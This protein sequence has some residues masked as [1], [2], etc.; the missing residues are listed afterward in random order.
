MNRVAGRSD[1]VVVKIGSLERKRGIMVQERKEKV[2]GRSYR[3]R[4]REM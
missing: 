3:E 2:G 4:K 1:M